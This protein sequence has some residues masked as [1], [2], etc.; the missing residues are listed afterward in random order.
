MASYNVVFR[1]IS[2]L[3]KCFLDDDI[4]SKH[5]ISEISLL[6]NGKI[7]FQLAYT[8]KDSIG[9]TVFMTVSPEGDLKDYLKIQRVMNVP[10]VFPVYTNRCD[11]NY[12]R[13]APGLYPDLLLPLSY[14]GRPNTSSRS[15]ARRPSSRKR[16]P[17]MKHRWTSVSSR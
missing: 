13:K 3:E 9:G 17:G 5:D 2:S 6:K 16:H 1:I 7:S 12:L 14:N 11:D 15:S 10:C 4:K 8:T